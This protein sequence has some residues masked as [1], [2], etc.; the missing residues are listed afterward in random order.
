MAEL[1]PTFWGI[2]T[3]Q[4]NSLREMAE[5]V[6]PYVSSWFRGPW[7]KSSNI[8]AVDFFRGTDI[9]ETAIAWN[10]RKTRKTETHIRIC[11]IS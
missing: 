7:G 9:V 2:L 4:A 1:T 5:E 11:D 10:L 8:V 6:N 3:Y